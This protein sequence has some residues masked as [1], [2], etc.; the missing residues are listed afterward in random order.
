MQR[1]CIVPMCLASRQPCKELKYCNPSGNAA[2]LYWKVGN[3]GRSTM[4]HLL[5]PQP[6]RQI[7]FGAGKISPWTQPEEEE[8]E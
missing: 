2:N 1:T 5:C 8:E 3:L 6:W 4:I 7:F